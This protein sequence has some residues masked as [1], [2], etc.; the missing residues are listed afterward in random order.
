VRAKHGIAPDD[1]IGA[2]NGGE[3]VRA[4]HAWDGTGPKSCVRRTD[5]PRLTATG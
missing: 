3:S 1:D 2:S 5:R 4:T